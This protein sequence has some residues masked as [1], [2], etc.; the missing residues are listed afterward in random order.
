MDIGERFHFNTA[1]SAI[2]ELNNEVA[3]TRT[4]GRARR[5]RQ[6]PP[7]AG[8]RLEMMVRLL[9]PFAPHMG[10]ELWQMMGSERIWDAPWPFADARFLADD[11]VE[12][13]V[14]VNG[15]VRDP[16][17]RCQG[18]RR[19]RRSWRREGAARVAKYLEGTTSS[20]K[21]SSRGG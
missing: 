6:R 15:K 12:L 4:P 20:R 7:S 5:H 19:R 8:R 14:Q 10:A 21:W 16:W 9:E 18:R 17:W 13:A 1:L 3:A 11:T 2:M